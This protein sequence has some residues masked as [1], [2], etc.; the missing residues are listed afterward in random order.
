MNG[1]YYY[2][3]NID[4]V[5]KYWVDKFIGVL[6]RIKKAVNGIP[7]RVI[8]FF[9]TAGKWIL[10]LVGKVFSSV[11]KAFKFVTDKLKGVMDGTLK[12]FNDLLKYVEN[13]AEWIVTKSFL[14]L[15]YFAMAIFNLGLQ[16]MT[17]FGNQA[18]NSITK[19]PG[20]IVDKVFS[21][22]PGPLKP[23]VEPLKDGLTQLF[24]PGSTEVKISI[25]A[26]ELLGGLEDAAKG[27]ADA[28]KGALNAIGI[29]V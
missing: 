1:L 17:D 3:H 5:I 25:D 2:Y 7:A 19:I 20:V 16:I 29:P 8:N 24:K 11:T 27:A 12:Y 10:D 13:L 28:G 22:I 9:E 15:V 23:M 21:F 14:Y 26:D 4:K 18:L 6:N